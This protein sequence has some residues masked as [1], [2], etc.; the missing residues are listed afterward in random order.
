MK[1]TRSEGVY[2]HPERVL[3]AVKDGPYLMGRSV[4]LVGLPSKTGTTCDATKITVSRYHPSKC[5]WR[6]KHFGKPKKLEKGL[7]R[8]DWGV[9]SEGKTKRWGLDCKNYLQQACRD[10]RD[11]IFT[12]HFSKT[13]GRIRGFFKTQKTF[14]KHR[15]TEGTERESREARRQGGNYDRKEVLPCFDLVP[16][17]PNLF[18]TLPSSLLPP[19]PFLLPSFLSFFP[20]LSVPSVPLCFKRFS[21]FQRRFSPSAMRT[22]TYRKSTLSKIGMGN[23]TNGPRRRPKILSPVFKINLSDAF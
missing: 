9:W 21:V 4:G 7:K 8:G 18:T 11:V 14:L 3:S 23:H 10:A 12:T 1:A 6:A 20:T 2:P 16:I 19:P 15:D 13:R 22:K 5:I 17:P